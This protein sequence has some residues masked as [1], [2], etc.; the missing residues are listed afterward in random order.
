L[1]RLESVRQELG[2][3]GES[4]TALKTLFI[5]AAPLKP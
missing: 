5:A 4:L 2:A 3:L 1:L